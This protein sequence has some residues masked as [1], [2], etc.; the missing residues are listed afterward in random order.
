[1]CNLYS[2]TRN[3]EAIRRLFQVTR[4]LTDNLPALPA[5]YPDTMASVVRAMANASW[6]IPAAESRQR[7]KPAEG[8]PLVC[9]RRMPA[10]FCHYGDLAARTG[11]GEDETGEHQLLAFVTSESNDIVRPVHA[12]AMP[13]LL[14]MAEEWDTWITGSVEQAIA[15]QMPLAN[16]MMCIVATGEKSEQAPV[17]ELRCHCL[18]RLS[19]ISN[20]RRTLLEEGDASEKRQ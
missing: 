3:Q 6:G 15:L 10:A 13:V 17:D 12:K 20:R 9:A 4:D 7:A 2:I 11:E 16:E 5:V 8:H 1:M 14:T 19:P 18:H